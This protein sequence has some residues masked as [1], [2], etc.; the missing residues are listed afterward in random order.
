MLLTIAV[1][2]HVDEP[3]DELRKNSEAGFYAG[4][5][6]SGNGST[7]KYRVKFDD[8]LATRSINLIKGTR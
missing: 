4:T 1:D 2:I 7:G 3:G 8:E 6:L 5:I